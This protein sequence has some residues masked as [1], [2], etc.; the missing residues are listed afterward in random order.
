MISC[1]LTGSFDCDLQISTSCIARVHLEIGRLLDSN[2][3]RL[4]PTAR[5]TTGIWIRGYNTITHIQVKMLFIINQYGW[6]RAENRTVPH[7]LNIWAWYITSQPSSPQR[8]DYLELFRHLGVVDD[9]SFHGNPKIQYFFL[10]FNFFWH[11]IQENQLKQS[12]E[13]RMLVRRAIMWEKLPQRAGIWCFTS[14]LSQRQPCC[15]LLCS[16]QQQSPHGTMDV[17]M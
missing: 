9:N 2:P 8:F 1:A 10:N 14:P 6:Q 11:F 17:H 16:P 3:S 5:G 7:G 4:Q 13:R 12:A 15:P